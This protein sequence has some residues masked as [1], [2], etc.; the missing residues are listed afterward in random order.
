MLV[1]WH[2]HTITNGSSTV[3]PTA[4]RSLTRERE[5]GLDLCVSDLIEFV[6]SLLC[7]FHGP[8][9]RAWWLNI[10]HGSPP[11]LNTPPP[12]IALFAVYHPWFASGIRHAST[13]NCFLCRLL[14]LP[15][16]ASA[17]YRLPSLPCVVIDANQSARRNPMTWSMRVDSDGGTA[18]RVHELLRCF[19][20]PIL[21]H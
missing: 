15:N 2:L 10:T 4:I 7:P 18:S 3:L 1:G 8:K 6:L 11:E 14:T 19:G 12:V 9:Y 16:A 13:H 5:H 21:P 20:A 17:I